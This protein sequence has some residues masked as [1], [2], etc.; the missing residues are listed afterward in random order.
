MRAS[1]AAVAVLLAVAVAAPVAHADVTQVEMV[2]GA[3]ASNSS[4]KS[5]AVLCPPGKK[6]ISAGGDVSPGTNEF[7][8]R[9]FVD[10][11]R[12]GPQL[13]GVTVRGREDELGTTQPWQVFAYAICAPAPGGLELVTTT[14]ASS[15][16]NKSALAACPS[17]KRLLGAAGEATGPIGEILLDGVLPGFYLTGATVNALEDETGTAQNWTVT[18]YAI[19]SSP[20]RGLQRVVATSASDSD[21]AKPAT[22]ICP[23][24]KTLLSAGGTINSPNGQILLDSIVP[25]DASFPFEDRDAATI[26]ALEDGDGNASDWSVTAY[27][28]CVAG[29]RLFSTVVPPSE[30]SFRT[31]WAP[32]PQGTESVGFGAQISEAIGRAWV[33]GL[34]TNDAIAGAETQGAPALPNP[35]RRWGLT[36][37]A[38]C[39]TKAPG[40]TLAS[41]TAPPQ[42]SARKSATA[43]CPGSTR[44]LG[45]GADIETEP[46]YHSAILKA[47]VPDAALRSVTATAVGIS[48]VGVS[49]SPRAWAVCGPAPAGL[50]RIVATSVPEREEI[51]VATATCPAAKHLVGTGAEIHDSDFQTGLDDVRPDPDL[52]R[53]TVVAS[54]ARFDTTFPAIWSASAYAIC[55]N[56]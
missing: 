9:V 1:V 12:P 22:V 26:W 5:V 16:A 49:W 6:V 32:C 38:I 7:A 18:A 44:V 42:D 23:A 31:V 40:T 36:S 13:N 20:V 14:S 30:S 29:V 55:V 45:A 43:T 2:R 19:C 10:A 28:V 3:S 8:N 51:A 27:G 50:Q 11:I 54:F 46:S 35:S 33:S 41:A 21:Q 25:Y 34:R 24:G 48:G 47:V 56:R 39:R 37:H 4:N 15:S 52:T 53:V 17:G